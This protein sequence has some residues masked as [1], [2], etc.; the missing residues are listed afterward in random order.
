MKH[1]SQRVTVLPKSPRD[2]HA[3][4]GS[5]PSERQREEAHSQGKCKRQ[6]KRKHATGE[7]ETSA[8]AHGNRG[9]TRTFMR[10]LSSASSIAAK[11][12]IASAREGMKHA[13]I[14]R[15]SDNA[16]TDN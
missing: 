16:T 2:N 6:R 12:G 7:P 8:K 4:T 15:I 5:S 11:S 14:E 10:F 9:N 3:A 1:E 13:A